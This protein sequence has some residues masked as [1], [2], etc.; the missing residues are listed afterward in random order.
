MKNFYADM[1]GFVL[2][3]DNIMYT[4]FAYLALFRLEELGFQKFKEFTATQDS[5]KIYHFINYL[6]DK[7]RHRLVKLSGKP[8]FMLLSYLDLQMMII[9]H[10][11]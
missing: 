5:A 2:R 1:S 10:D 9:Y 4:V 11:M 7:V 6:F 8:I 3:V